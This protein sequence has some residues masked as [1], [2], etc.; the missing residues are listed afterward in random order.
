MA[1]QALCE[2]LD[3]LLLQHEQFLELAEKKKQA[4]IS[5][6]VELLNE[7]VNKESKLVRQIA[8]TENKRQK[9]VVDFMLQKGF[10]QS[11]NT[12]VVDVIRLVSN[13]EDKLRLSDL[14]ERL[15]ATVDKLKLLN[16]I[17]MKLAE[18]S[19]AF[20]D[21]SLNLLTGIYD[22]EEFVYKN[23]SNQTQAQT[24]LKLFDSRA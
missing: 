9:A 13:A 16:Q 10:N 15:T 1:L 24:K 19:M 6:N 3:I 8:E 14:A 4:L 2:T 5:N 11:P 7:M 17:N 12:K 23:P 21:F 20:N 18:Q 22:D